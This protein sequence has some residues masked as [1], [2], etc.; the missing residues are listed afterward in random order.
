MLSSTEIEELTNKTAEATTVMVK[1][2]PVI[3]SSFGSIPGP[4]PTGISTIENKISE[5]LPLNE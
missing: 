2:H 5:L 1:E 3:A 4:K